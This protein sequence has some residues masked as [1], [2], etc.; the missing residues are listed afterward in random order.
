MR[1]YMSFESAKF[2]VNLIVCQKIIQV[3]LACSLSLHR[4][5]GKDLLEWEPI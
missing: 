2:S 1:V 5:H 3:I 4:A